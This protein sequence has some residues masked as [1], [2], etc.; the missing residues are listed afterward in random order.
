[1]EKMIHLLAYP[2]VHMSLKTRE[3]VRQH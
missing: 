3:I 1:M 2:V